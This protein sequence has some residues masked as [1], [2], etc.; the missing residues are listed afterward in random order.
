MWQFA[1]DFP[2]VT[3]FGR[4]DAVCVWGVRVTL[5]IGLF[6]FA[7]GLLPLALPDT[8]LTLALAPAR[9]L[10]GADNLFWFL[11][12]GSAFVGLAVIAWRG[13]LARWPHRSWP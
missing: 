12:F 2:R 11:V 1:R 5:A 4:L 9:R 3:W 7:A 13:R 8:R 6:L 10:A